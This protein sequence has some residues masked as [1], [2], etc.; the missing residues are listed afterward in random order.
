MVKD[1]IQF[2]EEANKPANYPKPMATL[3]ELE[4][5]IE[6]LENYLYP[7]FKMETCLRNE[8]YFERDK[9]TKQGTGLMHV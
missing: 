4:E 1:F 7:E 2:L 9:M 3:K 6:R 5:R 8:K